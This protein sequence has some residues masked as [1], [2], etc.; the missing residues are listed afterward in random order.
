MSPVAP[1]SNAADP[2]RN[3]GRGWRA[4]FAWLALAAII[5]LTVLAQRP[6][7]AT[8]RAAPMTEFSSARAM[9]M[10]KQIA[11]KPHPVGSAEHERVREQLVSDLTALGLPP[12]V[13]T[14]TGVET[15]GHGII[16]G[17]VSNIIARL[18]G[19]ANSRAVVLTAHYDSVE[20]APG[21]GD[22]GGGVVTI[23]ETLRALKAGPPLKNDVIALF[24]DGEEEG[25]LGAH[26]AA[27]HDPW[28]RDA[29]V[30]FNFEGRGDRGVSFLF[31]TSSGNQ[32]LVEEFAKAAPYP[33]G[34]SL[35]YSIYKMMPNDTDF[36]VFRR[37]G[38]AGLNFAWAERFEAY[39]SRLDTPA[40]LDER[41][42][43]HDGTY[44]LALT[45]HF[46]DLNLKQIALQDAK[47]RD[48]VF[49]DWFGPYF[50]HYPVA[51]VLPLFIAASIGMFGVLAFAIRKRLL[52]MGRL[53]AGFGGSV[54]ILAAT[55]VVTGGVF[56]IIN[57]AFR[58]RFLFGDVPSN[59]LL[60]VALLLFGTAAATAIFLWFRRLAGTPALG[61]GGLLIFWAATLAMTV[62]LPTGSY[63]AFWPMVFA[64]LAF[65][66]VAAGS[67]RA[68]W[69]AVV[70]TVLF[71]APFFFS[72]FILL[73]LNMVYALV[74]GVLLGLCWALLAPALELLVPLRNSA[75]AAYALLALAVVFTIA[76][77]AMSQP[78]TA[79]PMPDTLSYAI[80]N[81]Q[82]KA[83]WFSYDDAPDGWTASYLTRT[84]RN[85]RIPGYLGGT[86]YPVLW[87]PAPLLPLE[88]PS[89]EILDSQ[90]NGGAR[91]L[92]LRVRSPRNAPMLRIRLGKSETITAATIA[93]E[94]VS[95][96]ARKKLQDSSGWRVDLH[97]YGDTPVEVMLEI[98]AP[99]GAKTAD[100]KYWLSDR[101]YALPEIP[102]SNLPARP[103]R[104]MAWYGSDELIV[105]RTL[106]FCL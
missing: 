67:P 95:F 73:S 31:E 51:W 6:P 27:V 85:S 21:A 104:F 53:V 14:Y 23:L 15:I 58:A 30:L 2:L 60:A 105:S 56:W 9:E 59:D 80:D 93:G 77:V 101:S 47:G 61:A 79:H 45:R 34:S 87:N 94:A 48:E 82:A 97:G 36:T 26:A 5:V 68:A 11:Q 17:K 1:R 39:H 32:R 25:L 35:N 86:D 78:S 90:M 46:G 55:L 13:E 81:D 106:S 12:Q 54:A 20:R 69:I 40:N 99:R 66:L 74:C 50:V 42:L 65:A 70:P 52:S 37:A 41:S 91:S 96:E 4:L 71:F 10:L 100:C 63:I 57:R 83:V 38:I 19:S 7:R 62:V 88:P 29:G 98:Q 64:T 89:V 49:F 75:R 92:H 72:G 24:T 18:P 22:D 8:S 16:A 103:D 43:E 76:G 84:P 3:S 33:F 102:G 28:L 44:A